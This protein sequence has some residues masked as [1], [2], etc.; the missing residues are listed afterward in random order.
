MITL[1]SGGHGWVLVADDD[2]VTC[3]LGKTGAR[4]ANH[5]ARV[6]NVRRV[7][8]HRAGRFSVVTCWD[9]RHRVWASCYPLRALREGTLAGHRWWRRHLRVHILD[10]A[11]D[12]NN[13]VI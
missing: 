13:R 3:A 2:G 5:W 7:C 8:L 6:L 4:R 10:A 1:G 9:K 11:H 12:V